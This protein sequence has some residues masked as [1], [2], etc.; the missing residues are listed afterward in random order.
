MQ[1][2]S[3]PVLLV[4]DINSDI[5]YTLISVWVFSDPI[6]KPLDELNSFE[7][8]ISF[9]SQFHF[10]FYFYFLFLSLSQSPIY[11]LQNES[12][13]YRSRSLFNRETSDAG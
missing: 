5:L 10:Y 7:V 11:R 4:E 9:F 12:C 2:I 6:L 8:E 1:I 3:C 13:H